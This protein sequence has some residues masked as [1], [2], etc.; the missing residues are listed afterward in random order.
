[1]ALR[2]T[3][4]LDED[5]AKKIRI[6]QSELIRKGESASFSKVINQILRE[7]LPKRHLRRRV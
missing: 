4:M 3:I 1:M 7:A 2:V 6:I 5:L